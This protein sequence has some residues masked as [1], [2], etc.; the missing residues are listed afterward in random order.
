MPGEVTTVPRRTI[1]TAPA[2]AWGDRRDSAP[3]KGHSPRR[4]SKRA[5]TL[6][7]LDAA[8]RQ[9]CLDQLREFLLSK[10]DPILQM[11]F[12]Y[13]DKHHRGVINHVEFTTGMTALHYSY[14]IAS[15]WQEI[16]NEREDELLLEDVDATLA[17]AWRLF[18]RWCGSTFE[19]THNM[20]QRLRANSKVNN[21]DL[22]KQGSHSQRGPRGLVSEQ[23]VVEALIGFGWDPNQAPLF[24]SALDTGQEGFISALTLKFLEPAMAFHKQKEAQRRRENIV[25]EFQARR[26]HQSQVSLETFRRF[27]KQKFGSLFT[28]WRQVL[29]GDGSMT[30]QKSELYMACKKIHFPGN[31]RL[32]WQALDRDRSGLSTFEELDPVGAEVLAQFQ[33]WAVDTWGIHPSRRLF[34]SMDRHRTGRLKFGQ[35]AHECNA[36][37]YQHKAQA[38]IELLTPWGRKY[39]QEE[40]MAFIDVWKP[41]AWLTAKPNRVAADSFKAH[42]LQ[43]YGHYVK[44]WRI[45]I[46]KDNSNMCNWNE[47]QAAAKGLK[48]QDD[49]AGA[50]RALDEDLSGSITLREIDPAAHNA[51]MGFKRWTDEEFGGVRL[52]FKFMDT[53]KSNKLNYREFRRA[54]RDH[55]FTGDVRALFMSLDQ[56]Q[57]KELQYTEICFLD[58]WADHRTSS[59]KNTGD[60]EEGGGAATQ[61]PGTARGARPEGRPCS[62]ASAVAAAF[63]GPG[64][65]DIATGLGARPRHPTARHGGTFT[66]G[67]KPDAPTHLPLYAPGPETYNPSEDFTH[68]RR[69]PAWKIG[70]SPRADSPQTSRQLLGLSHASTTSNFYDR[71]G[72]PHPLAV[73]D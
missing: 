26:R 52:G 30:L 16:D 56:N 39:F 27:L 43:K 40:D 14:D 6:R 55:G 3:E 38:I 62:W 25:A 34:D 22:V 69:K 61:L 12:K 15:M 53:D 32:L 2:L 37:G 17:P 23:E 54:C 20:I 21:V 65:Y 70:P 41:P 68:K 19:S 9:E 42:L 33:V 24:Y 59:D 57:E 49:I 29:D 45:A 72:N 44:G 31:V 50:W 35:F 11:W 47:F 4:E 1:T 66:F 58:G 36:R 7:E 63:P 73:Y 18:K 5:T 67:V 10:G 8:S 51:L 28:A 71:A 64:S 46:D 60:G 13:F 48:V